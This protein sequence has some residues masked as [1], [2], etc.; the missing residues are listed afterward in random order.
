MGQKRDR[1]SSKQDRKEIESLL[2]GIIKKTSTKWS[3]F[4]SP[5]NALIP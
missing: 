1:E 3:K 2:E 5:G 4:N